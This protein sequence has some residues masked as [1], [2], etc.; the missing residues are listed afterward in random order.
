[1]SCIN[2]N[3]A[4]LL[5]VTLSSTI[6]ENKI[7][8]TQG[9][10]LK[11]SWLSVCLDKEE[12]MF[13]RNPEGKFWCMTYVTWAAATTNQFKPCA[14]FLADWVCVGVLH[15][16][17]MMW[18]LLWLELLCMVDFNILKGIANR[19][20]FPKI[21]WLLL[22]MLNEV[23]LCY[24]IVSSLAP[25]VAKWGQCLTHL[26]HSSSHLVTKVHHCWSWKA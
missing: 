17:G 15:M 26:H 8:L 2:D 19:H 14:F 21:P 4:L 11:T 6:F 7:P 5:R 20:H 16:Y 10:L 23:H 1:M 25:R 24:G 3:S 12:S 22:E 13:A 9:K 18:N